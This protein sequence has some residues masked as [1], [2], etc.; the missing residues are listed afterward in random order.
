MSQSMRG[1]PSKIDF[2]QIYCSYSR[3]HKIQDGFL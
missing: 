2:K 3:T 1:V